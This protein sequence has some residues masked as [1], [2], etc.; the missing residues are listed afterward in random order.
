MTAEPTPDQFVEA[1]APAAAPKAR[2][3][4][5]LAI[6]PEPTPAP[7]AVVIETPAPAPEAAPEPVQPAAE[8]RNGVT[9][10]RAGGK[11]AAVWDALDRMTGN[12]TS[13]TA[14][15]AR[16][17]AGELEINPSTMGVQF[18]KWKRFNGC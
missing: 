6:V 2:K 12:G 18:G 7:E 8:K 5:P 16:A 15:E 4:R 9:R 11:C 13:L 3:A 1:A 14:K 17:L 10:P